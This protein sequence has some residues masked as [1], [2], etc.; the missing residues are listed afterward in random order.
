MKIP[1]IENF[2]E[3]TVRFAIVFIDK[4]LKQDDLSINRDC[5]ICKALE[6][7]G[8]HYLSTETTEE[9]FRLFEFFGIDQ[10]KISLFA[11]RRQV[12]NYDNRSVMIRNLRRI[13]FMLCLRK[14]LSELLLN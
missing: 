4:Y 7:F 1:S 14:H 5:W 6:S 11:D 9:L 2:E 12:V 13:I 8:N 3:Q 10:G